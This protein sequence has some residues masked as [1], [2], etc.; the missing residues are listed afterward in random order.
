MIQGGDIT[1]AGDPD[2]TGGRSIYGQYFAGAHSESASML[3]SHSLTNMFT[4][5]DE[6]F[7][8]RHDRPGILSMANRGP[9]TNSSQ[10]R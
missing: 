8:L 3:L 1:A 10:V 7:T 6:N 2:G 4:T 5:T 9:N